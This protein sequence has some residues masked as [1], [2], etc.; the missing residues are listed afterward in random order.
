MDS[1]DRIQREE[2]LRRAVL[3]GDERA[4]QAWYDATFE[5]VH[6]YVYW[7]LGGRWDQ[8]EEVVQ[9]TWLTAVRTI[10]RFD[11]RQGSFLDWMR[12]LAA[13][14]V[15]HHLRSQQR[16]W[17]RE[18]ATVRDASTPCSDEER[19]RQDQ[20]AA[21]LAALPQRHEAVLRAKYLDGFSVAQI[22]ALG[23]ESPKAIE[24]LLTR[25]RQAFRELYDGQV[26]AEG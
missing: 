2:L 20:I 6:R 18:Q 4:W 22:A 1:D 26:F 17:K 5:K 19:Q 25:A 11:P 16:R 7:R 23:N 12:G 13:N 9:E 21:A 15:R 24:S 3:A 8:V 14:V 10:R